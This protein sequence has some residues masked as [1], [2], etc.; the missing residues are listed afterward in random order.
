MSLLT[1]LHLNGHWI[2]AGRGEVA[3]LALKISTSSQARRPQILKDTIS[4][5][6]GHLITLPGESDFKKVAKDFMNRIIAF[7]KPKKLQ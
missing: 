6:D 5:L 4:W 2:K 3:D 7:V 1:F